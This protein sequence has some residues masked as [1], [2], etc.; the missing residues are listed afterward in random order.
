MLEKHSGVEKNLRTKYVLRGSLFHALRKYRCILN[1]TYQHISLLI[2]IILTTTT[3]AT[4]GLPR[5]YTGKES[6]CQ[7]KRSKGHKLNPWVGK[8]FW[9]RKWQ[10]APV[11]L[12][13]KF[14][15]QRT[16]VGCSPWRRKEMDMTEQLNTN[17]YSN[18]RNNNNY[19]ALP[20]CKAWFP[21]A[22]YIFNFSSWKCSQ[23][24][25]I[26]ISTLHPEKWRNKEVKWWPKTREVISGEDRIP[27]PL[28]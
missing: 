5:W 21:S 1:H 16:L 25:I 10:T 12:P 22:T 23:G 8:I 7:F 13:G 26:S 24:G 6:T 11:F 3:I 14:Y 9:S 19:I 15:I 4:R 17:I 18:H 28:V 27:G 2:D 20:T